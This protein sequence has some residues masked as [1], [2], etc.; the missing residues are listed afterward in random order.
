MTATVP[1]TSLTADGVTGRLTGSKASKDVVIETATSDTKTLCGKSDDRA[2][3]V[4]DRTE[5]DTSGE[6]HGTEEARALESRERHGRK[7]SIHQ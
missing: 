5:G 3:S 2:G 6:S 7:A 1:A 4:E